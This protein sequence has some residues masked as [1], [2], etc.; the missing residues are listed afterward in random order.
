[1]CCFTERVDSQLPDGSLYCLAWRAAAGGSPSV[2][3]LVGSVSPSAPVDLHAGSSASVH[4]FGLYGHWLSSGMPYCATA[5][6]LS[7]LF[8]PSEFAYEPYC[9]LTDHCRY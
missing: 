8:E 2:Q 6:R 7:E 9:T 4:G 5:S 1:M 3:H